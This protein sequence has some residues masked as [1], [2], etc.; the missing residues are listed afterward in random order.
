MTSP[1]AA[2]PKLPF[3]A[4][5]VSKRCRS[6]W[7]A[8]SADTHPRA[9]SPPNSP[10]EPRA[11][12]SGAA[13][14]CQHRPPTPIPAHLDPKALLPSRARKRAVPRGPA[15]TVRRHPSRSPPPPNSPSEPRASASGAAGA[16][17][18]RP[19]APIPAHRHPQT[20]LPSRARKQA[21]PQ[22]LV[23]DVLR[24][25]S[26]RTVTPMGHWRFH[27]NSIGALAVCPQ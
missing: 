11:S 16:C 9:P 3:R 25:P 14:A 20:P 5:R 17:Q 2:T 4:A 6:G 22:R 23:S 1:R 8:T 26:P 13:A 24:H 19:P 18:H 10:S 7:S 21:V 12:A 15:S 27:S